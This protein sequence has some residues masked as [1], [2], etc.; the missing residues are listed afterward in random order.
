MLIDGSNS[1][2][3]TGGN[4]FGLATAMPPTKMILWLIGRGNSMY[5]SV[6]TKTNALLLT[7]V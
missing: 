7:A 5:S 3:F 1:C 6:L 4:G 2:Q